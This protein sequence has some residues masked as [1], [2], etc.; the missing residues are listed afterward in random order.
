MSWGETLFLKKTI[1]GTKSIVASDDVYYTIISDL[2]EI[3]N[4]QENSW[5]SL[6]Y[7]IKFKSGN[8]IRIVADVATGY[9]GGVDEGYFECRINNVALKSGYFS[10]SSTTLN[11]SVITLD[12]PIKKGDVLTFAVYS[13]MRPTTN[14]RVL[15]N[16]LNL[17]GKTIDQSLIKDI[18][19]EV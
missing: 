10:E 7:R 3:G 15:L 14:L 9:A 19:E 6:P 18:T 13:S 5:I 8:T 1:D 12:I 17:C 11:S 16:S 4:V 2:T